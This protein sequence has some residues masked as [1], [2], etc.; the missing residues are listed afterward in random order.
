[1]ICGD[2]KKL[3]VNV[4]NTV[5]AAIAAI[6]ESKGFT[7]DNDGEKIALM[8][9]ELSEALESLRHDDPPAEH[10]P[11]FRGS[12]EEFADCIIRIMHFGHVRSLRI[13][14]ALVE[15]VN[16]NKTRPYKHGKKF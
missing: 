11:E 13:A 16:F 14:E 1:M 4:F 7:V 15:K 9:S 2:E 10:V 8:H 5:A 12:E 3:F 6:S